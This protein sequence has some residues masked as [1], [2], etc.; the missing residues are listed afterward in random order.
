MIG[1]RNA[2]NQRAQAS[3]G[4]GLQ[5]T[6]CLTARYH[7]GFSTFVDLLSP[8]TLPGGRPSG[9]RRV[10]LKVED[11][12]GHVVLLRAGGVVAGKSGDVVEEGVCE[13]SSGDLPPRVQE[14]P[15]A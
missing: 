2:E 12:E 13:T 8:D 15:A 11:E 1:N 4:T 9:V 7:W 14:F 10:L 5:C 6:S 3:P